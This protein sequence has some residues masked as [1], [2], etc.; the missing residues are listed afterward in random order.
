MF[1]IIVTFPNYFAHKDSLSLFAIQSELFHCSIVALKNYRGD[2]SVQVETLWIKG[3]FLAN[4]AL[5]RVLSSEAS[6]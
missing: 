6:L 2:I 5:S 3:L 1:R 4:D